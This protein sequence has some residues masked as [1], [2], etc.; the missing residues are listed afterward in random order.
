MI[1]LFG[2]P[3]Q[4]VLKAQI[5]LEELGI[6]YRRINDRLLEPGSPEHDTFMQA[7]PTGQVP[8]LHD[9]QT[10]A[11]LFE[12]SA[13]LIYL[14]EKF[15]QF[16]PSQDTPLE[17]AETLKWLLFESASLTPAMLDI[18]HY[19]L[20]AEDEH[21]YSEQRA[22]TRSRQAL[23]V[24]ENRLSDGR[25]YFGGDYSIAD[26]IVYPWMVILE[27]FADIPLSDYP[28]LEAWTTRVGQRP[29]V[30]KAEAP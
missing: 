17:R 20:Q 28:N 8:A 15:G 9:P 16:L 25:E 7:S 13:I 6:E 21:P 18:Y 24:L 26:M 27:D 4:N 5:L 30:K 1:E 3:T 10:G 22:R 12:S 2:H 11:K 29:A 23:N 14:A 19:T